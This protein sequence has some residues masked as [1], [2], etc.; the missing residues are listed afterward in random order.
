MTIFV[1]PGDPGPG[2]HQFELDDSHVQPEIS[3]LDATIEALSALL[4]GLILNGR[5]ELLTIKDENGLH[6][7]RAP[8]LSVW[9]IYGG[10]SDARSAKR[11]D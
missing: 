11:H 10:T 3:A 2:H 8:V 6:S 7:Y 5:P 9:A 1:V 4:G